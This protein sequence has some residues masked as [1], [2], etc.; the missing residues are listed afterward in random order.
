MIGEVPAQGFDPADLAWSVDR[1]IVGNSSLDADAASD[2]TRTAALV[3]PFVLTLVTGQPGER[4]RGFGRRSLVYAETFLIRQGFTSLAKD[5]AGPCP[6]VCVSVRQQNVPDD[7]AFDV[8]RERTFHSM[9]S[10]HTSS[11]WTGAA[12]GMTEHLL[13]RP[14]ASWFRARWC[15]LPGGRVGGHDLGVARRGRPAFPFGLC[16][17]RRYRHCDRRNGST[18]ASWRATATVVE[19]MGADD[20]GLARRYTAGSPGGTGILNG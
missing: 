20:G 15:R 4:W 7:S 6:P 8:S 11:A 1:D 2:W 9:P 3:F 5:D 10:G 17:R 16:G 12:L 19:S 18:A 13:G 14:E